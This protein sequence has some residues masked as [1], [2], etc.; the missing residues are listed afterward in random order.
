MQDTFDHHH[1]HHLVVLE[2]KVGTSGSGELWKRFACS[3]WIT[4][5]SL[6]CLLH[7]PFRVDLLWFDICI[8]GGDSIR[9]RAMVI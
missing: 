7:Q 9:V 1:H 3:C 8:I 2:M 6:M 4:H 5:I